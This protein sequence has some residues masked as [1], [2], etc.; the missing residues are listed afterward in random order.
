MTLSFPAAKVKKE[1]MVSYIMVG[2]SKEEAPQF[3]RGNPALC[4][5]GCRGWVAGVLSIPP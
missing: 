4:G 5:K 1:D 2:V 3:L